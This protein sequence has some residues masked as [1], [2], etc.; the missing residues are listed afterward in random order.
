[1]YVGIITARAVAES[2]AEQAEGAPAVAGDLAELPPLIAADQQL[3]TALHVLLSASGTGLPVLD[4]DKGE[5]VGWLSH[6]GVLRALH[7][8]EA[9]RAPELLPS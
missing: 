4:S 6:Q 7:S 1:A 5:P 8:P 9:S 3:A 2:L